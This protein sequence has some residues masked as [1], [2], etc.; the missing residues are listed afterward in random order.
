MVLKKWT[1]II[2]KVIF[3]SKVILITILHLQIYILS[4]WVVLFRDSS[5]S[6]STHY[7]NKNKINYITYASSSEYLLISKVISSITPLF[8]IIITPLFII[9][10]KTLS[11]VVNYQ[12]R[13]FRR[14]LFRFRFFFLSRWLHSHLFQPFFPQFLFFSFLFSFM[15]FLFSFLLLFKIELLILK[16]RI[17]HGLKDSWKLLRLNLFPI[18]KFLFL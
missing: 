14:L 3:I 2:S 10:W 18:Q 15:L 17:H 13:V 1:S 6:T 9:R 11:I 8:I 5:R 12:I 7:I 16:F 4:S